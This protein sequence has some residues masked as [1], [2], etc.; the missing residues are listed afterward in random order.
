MFIKGI[1]GEEGEVVTVHGNRV[2]VKIKASESCEKCRICKRVSATE[3]MLEAFTERPVQKGQRV[4]VAIRPGTI[5]KSALMLYIIPLIGLI[6]G[7]YVGKSLILL[8]HLKIKGELFPAISSLLFLFLSFIPIRIY[9]RKK[10]K[11]ARF[12]IYIEPI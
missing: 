2:T 12:R 6:I 7:Y 3:M 10:Q 4:I 5:F 11:D 1:R 9:D 8:L